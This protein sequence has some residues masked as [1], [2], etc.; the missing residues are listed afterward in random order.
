[1]PVT[2]RSQH[3]LPMIVSVPNVV[4]IRRRLGAARIV[5]QD[6][7]AAISVSG[8]DPRSDSRPFPWEFSSLLPSH[9]IH[10]PREVVGVG[11]KPLV[12][13]WQVWLALVG[14]GLW[15]FGEWLSRG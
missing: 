10:S 12:Q 9:R 14:G 8:E 2:H 13:P 15:L 11:Q 6:F 1:M 5:A 7:R 4:D 3:V